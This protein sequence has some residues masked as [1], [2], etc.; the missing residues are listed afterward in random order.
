MQRTITVTLPAKGD[1]VHI[2]RSVVAS[3]AARL[4]FSVDAIDD[5]RL[6]VDEACG[7]LLSIPGAEVLTLRLDPSPDSLEMLLS[8][9]GVYSWPPAGQN[10]LSWE[11]LSALSDTSTFEQL[12]GEPTIRVAKRVH[13][14]PR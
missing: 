5:L 6:L 11:I 7:Q 12:D 3:I 14:M 4:D 2:L 8:S 10:A 1:F 13:S 9:N